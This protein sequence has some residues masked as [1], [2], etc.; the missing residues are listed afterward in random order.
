MHK[1]LLEEIK[2]KVLLKNLRLHLKNLR[3]QQELHLLNELQLDKLNN[4]QL[5]YSHKPHLNSRN[6][7]NHLSDKHHQQK[8][9]SFFKYKLH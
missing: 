1:W 7:I 3:L 5:K 6:L 8:N 4:H 9:D 2:I